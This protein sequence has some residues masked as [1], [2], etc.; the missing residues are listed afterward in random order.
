VALTFISADSV[1]HF[2]LIEKHQGL[3]LPREH[4][5][6]FEPTQSF[7]EQAAMVKDGAQVPSTGGI[8]GKRPSKKDKLR[9]AAALT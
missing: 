4:I 6:G 2:R 5:L 1:A 9:A 7:S 8:K 3:T